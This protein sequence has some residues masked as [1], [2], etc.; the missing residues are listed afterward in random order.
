MAKIDIE[1]TMRNVQAR[2]TNIEKAMTMLAS[3]NSNIGGNTEKHKLNKEV[4]ESK[5]ISNLGDTT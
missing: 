2:M 4:L 3:A 1:G 5:T